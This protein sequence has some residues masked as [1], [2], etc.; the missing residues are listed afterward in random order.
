LAVRLAATAHFGFTTLRFGDA[1]TYISAARDIARTGH[2]PRRTGRSG[3]LAPGYPVFLVL[4]TLGRPDRIAV[5]KTANCILGALAVL[6]LAAIASRLFHSRMA[7]TL[8]GVG[9]AIDPGFLSLSTDVQGEPLFLL[10]LL[11][12]GYLLLAAV[13]RPSSNLA[14]ASGALLAC[15][16]LTRPSALVLVAL[17]AA[18]ML[19]RR[20]PRRARAHLAGSAAAGFCLLLAPWTLRNALVYREFVLINDAGGDVFYQG[21]SDWTVRF[22]QLRTLEEYDAWSAAMFADLEKQTRAA[23]AASGGSPSALSRFLIRQALQQRR[24]DPAGWLRLELQK[25]L[26]WLRPYPNPMFWPRWTVWSVGLFNGALTLLATV[27][28]ALARRAGARAF[29]LV[30]L[31][32]TLLFHVAMLVVWRYRIPYWDPVIVLYGALGACELLRRNTGRLPMALP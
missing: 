20:Y 30:F 19:D 18:P 1:R 26:D 22:Y 8:A 16:A 25:T 27:G 6:V 9:G 17:L 4:T 11:C 28:L 14:L 21:N 31:G 23:E 2:Y 3:F 15:A 5:A 13:D 10:L 32:L 24:K 29:V 12:A 7:A